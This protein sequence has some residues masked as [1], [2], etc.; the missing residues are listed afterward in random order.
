MNK[1]K[2]KYLVIDYKI[3]NIK[4]NARFECFVIL[5]WWI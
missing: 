5:R 3:N 2:K 1:M 4:T